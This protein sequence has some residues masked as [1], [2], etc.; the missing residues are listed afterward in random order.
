MFI[1]PPSLFDCSFFIQLYP[2]PNPWGGGWNSFNSGKHQNRARVLVKVGEMKNRGQGSSAGAREIAFWWRLALG[3]IYQAINENFVLI[4]QWLWFF[5]F[6]V[7]FI[8]S[9]RVYIPLGPDVIIFFLLILIGESI[10]R[11]DIDL[12]ER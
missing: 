5:F 12:L 4:F 11:M 2:P 3:G 1:T 10:L 9:C 6:A 8:C 7:F